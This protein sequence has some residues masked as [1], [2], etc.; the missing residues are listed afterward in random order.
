MRKSLAGWLAQEV[1]SRNPDGSKPVVALMDGQ[2]SFWS[3][4]HEY[5]PDVNIIEIL[6]LL[7]VCLYVWSAAHL[8]YEKKSQ[9]ASRFAK[10]TIVRLLR[11]EVEG[12]I[13]GLRWKGTHKKLSKKRLKEMERICGY[14]EN[15]RHRMAYNR[16]FGF[17]ELQRDL[18]FREPSKYKGLLR[19]TSEKSRKP[20][21]TR[22]SC[23]LLK[24]IGGTCYKCRY[25][26]QDHQT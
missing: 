8:F 26:P 1:Q 13:R 9:A 25:V 12:V 11:G 20:V 22:I 24:L 21:D 6:D 15:N 4:L 5:F 10:D 16:G 7:H 18:F 23:D 17:V 19:I 14:F 2:E 3:A